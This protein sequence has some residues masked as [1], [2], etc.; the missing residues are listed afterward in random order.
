MTGYSFGELFRQ[1]GNVGKRLSDLGAAE[2]EAWNILQS[3]Y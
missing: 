3:I 2:G 1:F